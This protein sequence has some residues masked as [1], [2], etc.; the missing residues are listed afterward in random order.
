[1]NEE[2]IDRRV[3][4]TRQI[5][6]EALLAL[7]LEKS[8]DKI[9]IQE[10]IDRANVGRATFYNHY[11]DK[12]DLLLRG[13]AEIVVPNQPE[14]VAQQTHHHVAPEPQ[15]NT[16]VTAGMFEHSR[17]NG[18]LHQIVFKR[19]RDHPILAKITAFLY[20]R[21]EDRLKQLTVTEGALSVPMPVMAQF[22]TGGLL[23][24]IQW[25]HDNDFP[26]SSVEMDAFFQQIA[27]PGTLAVLGKQSKNDNG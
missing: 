7:M 22:I 19:N 13:I 16:L 17:Q 15:P 20:A 5:I 3:Q 18:R 24:L 12:D 1:M 23:S 9:T 8:Y 14:E 21:V 6:C 2:K 25:W 11:Q 4:R 10:I 27:M 26:Y